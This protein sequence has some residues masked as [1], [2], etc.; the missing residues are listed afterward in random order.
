MLPLD[1]TWEPQRRAATIEKTII[2]RWFGASAVLDVDHCPCAAVFDIIL[3]TDCIFSTLLVPNLI[4]ILLQFS[5]SRTVVY[6]AHEI[7][8]VDAN[9]LFVAELSKRFRV[10][11]IAYD[12]LHP[13]YRNR[14][15]QVLVCKRIRGI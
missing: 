14:F 3:L 2:Q 8:D 6:C 10:K 5:S 13:D 7:R 12:K 11:R 9:A 15:I 4:D 1:W